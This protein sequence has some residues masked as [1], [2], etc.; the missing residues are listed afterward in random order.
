[1][2]VRG[3]PAQE[4][5]FCRPMLYPIKLQAPRYY[6]GVGLKIHFLHN[7]VLRSVRSVRLVCKHEA[8]RA[9]LC[10][11]LHGVKYLINIPE[12]S[13]AGKH[14]LPRNDLIVGVWVPV[15][16]EPCLEHFDTGFLSRVTIGRAVDTGVCGVLEAGI[17]IVTVREWLERGHFGTTSGQ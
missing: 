15:E 9:S 12:E 5:R 4:H 10:L 3:I 14:W 7:T 16:T 8:R 17:A 6:G 11:D 2:A 1:M 13:F